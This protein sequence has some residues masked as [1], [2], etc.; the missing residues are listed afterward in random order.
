MAVIM[1][2]P[3][4]AVVAAVS[5]MVAVKEAPIQQDCHHGDDDQ[6]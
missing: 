5:V 4:T 6:F 3:M 1:V 2:M